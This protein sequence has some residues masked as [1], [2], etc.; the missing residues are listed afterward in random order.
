MDEVTKKVAKQLEEACSSVLK[1]DLQEAERWIEGE[2]ENIQKQID[3]TKT[4]MNTTKIALGEAGTFSL[5]EI[6]SQISGIKAKGE[7]LQK[8]FDDFG[9]LKNRANEIYSAKMDEE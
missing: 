3:S 2:Q 6:D 7:K 9:A 8:S 1:T 4:A 5:E